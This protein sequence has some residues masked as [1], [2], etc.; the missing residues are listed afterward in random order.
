M[1]ITHTAFQGLDLKN[2]AVP[3]QTDWDKHCRTDAYF[4][5]HPFLTE[6]AALYL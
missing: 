2:K 4:E 6:D 3:V 5:G 1:A